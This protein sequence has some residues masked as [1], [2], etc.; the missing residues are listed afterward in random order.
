MTLAADRHNRS[1]SSLLSRSH[2]HVTVKVGRKTKGSGAT[3][4]ATI[5]FFWRKGF[6]LQAARTAAPISGV[7]FG[8]LCRFSILNCCFLIFAASSIPQIVIAAVS[9]RLK[10]CVGPTLCLIR[11]WSS[12]IMLFKY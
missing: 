3:F 5:Q 2:I 6:Q 4:G 12:A 1:R 9:K 10:P 11:R 7:D 8:L